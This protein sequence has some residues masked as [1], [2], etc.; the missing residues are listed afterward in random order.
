[1]TAPALL[2]LDSATLLQR[3]SAGRV[4]VCASH[5]GVFAAFLAARAEVRAIILN[6]AGVG[7]DAAGVAGLFWLDGLG[8]GA[9]AVDH[10][11]AR[12]GDGRDMVESGI[13]STANNVAATMGCRPGMPVAEAAALLARIA[14]PPRRPPPEIGETRR[15]IA[16]SGHREVW[17][18]DSVSLEKEEDRRKI[19]VTGSHGG[20]LGGEPKS[21]LKVDAFAAFFNDAGGGKDGAGFTRLAVLDARGIAAATVSAASARIGDGLSTYET[22]VLS[23]VN[24]A[25][26]RLGLAEGMSARQAVARLVGLA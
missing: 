2:V 5:G 25:A 8:I 11:S 16:N 26:K 1:M 19:L 14:D 15:R 23:R 20:L 24:E 7:R 4:A 3:S 18:L 12:I 10:Q 9:C 6:D 22:G 17:A 13:V 21:A